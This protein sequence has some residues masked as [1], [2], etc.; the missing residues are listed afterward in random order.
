[1]AIH[2]SFP[3]QEELPAGVVFVGTSQK[4]AVAHQVHRVHASCIHMILEM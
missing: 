2:I 4:Q 1:M 3:K